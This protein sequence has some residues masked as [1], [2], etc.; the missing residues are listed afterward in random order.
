MRVIVA[1][2]RDFNN[3]PL[4]KE[5]LDVI[6]SKLNKDELVVISGTAPGADQLG[7]K[8]AMGNRIKLERFPAD[9]KRFGNAAGMIRNR[10][11]A[12][13]GKAD[14]LVAFWDGKSS[15]TGGMIKIARELDLDIRIIN[16]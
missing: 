6:F 13:D 11:M 3:Y 7:E 1:G 16:Y 14:A 15:G 9:W 2:G 8:Y 10:Q 4:L 12:V 5:S